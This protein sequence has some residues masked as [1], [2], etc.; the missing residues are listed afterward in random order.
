[1][2]LHAEQRTKSTVLYRHG[3]EIVEPL[4]AG[5]APADGRSLTTFGTFGPILSVVQAVLKTPGSVTWQH[6]EIGVTGR[7]AV[8]HFAFAGNPMVNLVGCCFPDGHGKSPIGLSAGSHGEIAIDPSTGAILRVHIEADLDGFITLKRSGLVVSYG[9]VEIS[10][11][12]YILPLRSVNIVRGRTVVR[13][14]QWN[15]GFPTWGPY[16]TQMNVFTFDGYHMFQGSGRMLPGFDP[17]P[18]E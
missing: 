12:T 5:H 2:P 13:F 14:S 16:E 15:L 4:T 3:V 6:W 8:F 10:G 1:M 9:P 18:E 11:N 17:R 7:L